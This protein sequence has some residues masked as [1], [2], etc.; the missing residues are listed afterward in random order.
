MKEDADKILDAGEITQTYLE[1]LKVSCKGKIP[2]TYSNTAKLF[3][4]LR[5]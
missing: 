4:Y 1:I 2:E 5:K 3:L